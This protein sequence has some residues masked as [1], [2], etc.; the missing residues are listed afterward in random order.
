M[1]V[2]GKVRSRKMEKQEEKNRNAQEERGKGGL[3]GLPMQES[4][5]VKYKDLEEYKRQGYGV[6]G[7]LQPK[8]TSRGAGATEAPTISGAAVS[9]EDECKVTEHQVSGLVVA[10]PKATVPFFNPNQETLFR[11][12]CY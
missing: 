7:H 11:L 2:Y 9:S 6:E 12:E 8:T 3:E 4:P 5:Y 10:G 1:Y